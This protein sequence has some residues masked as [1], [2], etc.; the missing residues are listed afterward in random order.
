MLLHVL[1]TAFEKHLGACEGYSLTLGPFGWL[2][3]DF[4]KL[5]F[6]YP[7][8]SAFLG[9]LGEAGEGSALMRSCV[10]SEGSRGELFPVSSAS[11]G[12]GCSFS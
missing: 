1:G 7:S 3:R 5:F 2:N 12:S 6:K 8:Y 9:S 10:P 11:S 4:F